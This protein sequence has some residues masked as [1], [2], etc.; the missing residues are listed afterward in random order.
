M[1]FQSQHRFRGDIRTNGHKL[2]TNKEKKL[3]EWVINLDQRGLLS[4][5]AFVENMA[6]YLLTQRHD[7]DPPPWVSKNRVYNLVQRAMISSV[8]YSHV[9]ITTAVPNAKIRR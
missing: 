7:Q 8:H 2:T 6:N 9:A 4:R 5:S 1:M 3:I